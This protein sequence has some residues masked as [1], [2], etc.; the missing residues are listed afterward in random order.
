VKR[1]ARI[2]GLQATQAQF[3]AQLNACR[4]QFGPREY[5]VVLDLLARQLERERRRAARWLRRVA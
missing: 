1:A 2:S 4:E 3:Q 5:A